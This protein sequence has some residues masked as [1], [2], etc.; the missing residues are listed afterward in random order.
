MC[1]SPERIEVDNFIVRLKSYFIVDGKMTNEQKIRA[2]G[3]YQDI[4][5]ESDEVQTAV[6]QARVNFVE[7]EQLY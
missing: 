6:V 7:S 1:F 5:T 4:S 3:P 2:I